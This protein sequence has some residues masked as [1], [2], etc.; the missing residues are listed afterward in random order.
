MVLGW[1]RG[2]ASKR[3]GRAAFRTIAS[4]YASGTLVRLFW[5]TRECWSYGRREHEDAIA[6]VFELQSC[7][8][9]NICLQQCIKYSL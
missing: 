3:R 4:A 6:A 7:R 1:Y 2:S 5:V 9:M 8:E